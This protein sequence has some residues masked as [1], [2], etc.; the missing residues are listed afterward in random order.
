MIVTV[1]VRHLALSVLFSCI[2]ATFVPLSNYA[3]DAQ[4]EPG[5][6]DQNSTQRRRY[7]V[8]D[9]NSGI[10]GARLFENDDS[11]WH[12]PLNDPEWRVSEKADHMKPDD[13]VLGFYL[14]GKSWAL[15]WWIMKNHHAANLT[16]DGQPVLVAFCEA[17]GS[18]FALNPIVDGRRLTF[19]I[20]GLYNGS[21][22]LADDQTKSYWAPFTGEALEG[23]L[24]GTK[25]N[26]MELVQCRWNEWNQLHPQ[27][28]VAY[29]EEKMRTGHGERFTPG[30]PPPAKFLQILLKPPDDRLRV[31]DPVLGVSVGAEARAYPLSVLD[32]APGDDKAN[33]V[34]TDTISKNDIVILHR[35]GSWLT[36]VF[37]PQLD[38]KTLRFTPGNDGRFIDATYHSHWSF[39]GEALD[40]PVAGQKLSPIH[41][42]VEDWYI[43][44]AYFPET[45]I[46]SGPPRREN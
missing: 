17:C 20:A 14:H 16:L 21:I 31:N 3:A 25:L 32:A 43:W 5:K 22:L 40:G 35:R 2:V 46:Y 19:Y 1:N 12:L 39:E 45:S 27:G 13:Q 36:T 37:S 29:A 7:R 8:I 28:L 42:R 23:P 6:S 30:G 4:P 41:S 38:G 44:A 26:Y 33:V 18:A 34:I 15:P 10:V 11:E 9:P 24:K